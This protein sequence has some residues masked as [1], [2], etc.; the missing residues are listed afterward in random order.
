MNFD[1]VPFSIHPGSYRHYFNPAFLICYSFLTLLTFCDIHSAKTQP[2]FN[3]AIQFHVTLTMFLKALVENV[4]VVGVWD[5]PNILL[6]LVALLD[7][8]YS[9]DS[10]SPLFLAV[11]EV[12]Y[13]KHS[14]FL[15][16]VLS[17]T[18]P[19]PLSRSPCLLLHQENWGNQ[20]RTPSISSP[21]M[22]KLIC[23]A[24]SFP[25]DL[26]SQ[27]KCC[28]SSCLTLI[29][30]PRLWIPSLLPP[31]RPCSINLPL[32]LPCISLPLPTSSQ[33]PI[34]MNNSLPT[35][36]KSPPQSLL[37]PLASVLFLF[38]SSQSSC[39]VHYLHFPNACPPTGQPVSPHKGNC[40]PTSH[41]GNAIND[42]FS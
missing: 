16:H 42:P 35:S 6:Q 33:H 13:T 12:L 29:L 3:L 11:P 8:Q 24:P 15:N 41:P 27:W 2:Q 4:I 40:L 21:A 14:P 38:L 31:L 20:S 10:V 37:L 39:R 23:L 18:S 25:P 22:Y 5:T 28:P 30:P 7:T 17:T 19:T 9:P 34:N 32:S 26:L 36:W 1:C